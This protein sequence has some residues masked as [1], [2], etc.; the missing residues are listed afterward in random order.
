MVS[1][2]KIC[3]L[4]DCRTHAVG[5]PARLSGKNWFSGTEIF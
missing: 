4:P 1:P 5:N 3:D 2:F